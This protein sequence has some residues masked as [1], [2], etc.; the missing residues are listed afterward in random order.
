[1]GIGKSQTESAILY[2]STHFIEKIKLEVIA[3]QAGLSKF[4]FHR[5]FVKEQNCTPLAYL[6]DLRLKHAI[7]LM[8]IY[9]NMAL[10]EV[11]YE[12]GFSSPATFNRSFKK[13]QAIAPSEYRK[14]HSFS[15]ISRSKSG[16]K[17]INI[18]YLSSKKIAVQKV[19]LTMPELNH[20][21][22]TLINSKEDGVITTIGFYL[23]VPMHV[24]LNEC[25]YYIGVEEKTSASTNQF[26][27]IPAGYY[28]AVQIKGDFNLLKERLTQHKNEIESCGYV[29]DS[30]IGYEKIKLDVQLTNFDFLTVT[31]EILIK[32]RRK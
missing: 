2:L 9:P 8:K 13:H 24:P 4:H 12:S 7:H 19:G 10:M 31:R 5:L 1:M 30:L 28:T 21:Y 23:D 17:R 11:A 20:S 27:T 16:N 15:R 26:L 29:I 3:K 18:Q 32:V 25:R 22:Q 14:K 6:E